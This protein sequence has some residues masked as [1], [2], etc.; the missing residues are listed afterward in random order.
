MKTVILAAGY[1]TRLYPLTLDRPKCL[2]SVG[3]R[4]L[5]DALCGKLAA[6]PEMD[7]AV[8]VTNDKFFP[9]LEAWR[10]GFKSRVPLRIV[11]DGTRS[12]ETRLGAVGDLALAIRQAEISGDI[13]MLASDNLFDEGFEGFI[14]FCKSK[15]GAV[16][17]G[18]HDIGD[19]AKAAKKFGVIQTDAAGRVTGIEEKPECPQSPLIGM[20][21]YYFPKGTLAFV[22]EY[23]S[24]KSAQDAPGHYIRWLFGRTAIFGFLFG[25]MWYDIGDLK[26]LEEANRIFGKK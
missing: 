21:V 24:S 6:V 20:G 17:I 3:G 26:A 13:L 2:L 23:L 18:L 14:A 12:N 5:L 7:E 11:N 22:G 8:I 9:Q 10:L 19:P 15:G 25:G 16:C 4:T 1:A